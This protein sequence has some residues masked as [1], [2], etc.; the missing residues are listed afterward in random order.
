MITIERQVQI[1]LICLF[2]YASCNLSKNQDIVM[3]YCTSVPWS[4]RKDDI[5]DGRRWAITHQQNANNRFS[6]KSYN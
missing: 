6:L 1:R 5:E 2:V 4:N 3:K